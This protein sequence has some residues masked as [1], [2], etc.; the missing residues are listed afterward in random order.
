MGILDFGL[1]VLDFRLLLCETGTGTGF[2][3]I[4]LSPYLHAG[5]TG[6]RFFIAQDSHTMTGFGK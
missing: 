4:E 3:E 6:W 5:S 2:F 1:Q